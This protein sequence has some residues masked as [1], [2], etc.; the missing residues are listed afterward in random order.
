[1]QLLPEPPAGLNRTSVG[2]KR[3]LGM[4][5][6]GHT[7]VPQ[8]NQRGIETSRSASQ[9]LRSA[10]PQSNQRGIETKWRYTDAGV[11]PTASIEPV[12]D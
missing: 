6:E 3:Q 2:L 5:D 9:R 10:R 12:W 4:L 8:S 7:D 11:K 1:M